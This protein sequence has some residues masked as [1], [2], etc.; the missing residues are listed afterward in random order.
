MIFHKLSTKQQGLLLAILA[1]CIFGFTD[2]AIKAATASYDAFAVALYMNI[3]TILFLIPFILHQGGFKKVLKVQNVKRHAARCY[4]MLIN[5]LCIIYAFSHIPLANAYTIIFC[6]PFIINIL[7]M[8]L[9]KESISAYRWVAITA[10]MVGVLI[11]LRPGMVPISPAIIATIVGTIVFALSIIVT[12]KI[13]PQDHWLSYMTYLMIFQTP[14]LVAIVWWR[15]GDLL[16]D[17]SDWPMM[18][19]FLAGGLGYVLGLSAQPAALKRIDASIVGALIYLV[20]PWGIFYG[21]FVFGDVLDRWT[22]VGAAIIIL[23]G[24]YLIYREKKESSQ[25]ER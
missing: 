19:W 3:F 14:V 1:F 20:F 18:F 15:G 21:Y 2:T 12:K 8:V 23:S 10:G 17:L 6:A 9:L 13:S 25:K 5:F 16:P 24:L 7:A 22:G 4:L 11:A